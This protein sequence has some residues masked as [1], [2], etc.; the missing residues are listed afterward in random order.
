MTQGI[1]LKDIVALDPPRLNV[2]DIGAAELSAHRYQ[3]LLDQ[4]IASV[5]GFEPNPEELEKLR[6]HGENHTYL[7][8]FLG[9]GKKRVFYETRF[10]GCSSLF[11][12]DPRIIDLFAT[13]GTGS[14]S[15]NFHV[16]KAHQVETVRLDDIDG[17]TRPDF[18]K[19]D[20]QGAELMVLE[21]GIETLSN[22]VVLEIEV[23]FVPVYKG[24]PLFG[25][26]HAFMRDQG[27]VLHKLLDVSG[28]AILPVEHPTNEFLPISQALWA[29]A[30]F[31]KDYFSINSFKD[32]QLEKA[33]TI[34]NDVYNSYDLVFRL[35]AERDR[36]MKSDL[37]AA[38]ERFLAS[39]QAPPAEFH[40]IRDRP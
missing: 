21:N 22:A 27:F 1:F 10:P 30:V 3:T 2:M 14:R 37:S 4:G 9:D 35:L 33:A 26:I 12:P 32:E 39:G 7:P 16:V 17:L 18:I 40:T 36:R 24:Q 8:Y 28:R 31:V 38:Y 6:A 34:L 13:I 20:V 29:D 23:E 25:D 15:G 11:L 19:V 5:T